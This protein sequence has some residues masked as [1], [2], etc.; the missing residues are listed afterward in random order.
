MFRNLLV[1][2]ILA[3]LAG[4]STGLPA[5]ESDRAAGRVTIEFI[6][7]TNSPDRQELYSASFAL[8]IGVSE[9]TNG[10]R[11]LPGVENDIPA[12]REA[13]ERHG[14][15]C[16]V[17]MN[18]DGRQLRRAF[19]D[20]IAEYGGDH[21]HRLLFYFAGHGHTQY[22][23]EMK[24]RRRGYIV[25]AP[26]AM[27]DRDW[28]EFS[29]HAVSMDQIQTYARDI[30][31][32]HAIFLFDSCF[33]GTIFRSRSGQT[34][35]PAIEAKVTRPVRQ[36]ITAGGPDEPVP[37]ESVFR[38]VLVR[39]LDGEAGIYSQD[40]YLTGIELGEH[41]LAEV[42]AYT[43]GAQTPEHGKIRDPLLDQGDF[44]FAFTG[45][46][47]SPV[48]NGIPEF[49]ADALLEQARQREE[50]E[51]SQLAL[52]EKAKDAWRT[53]EGIESNQYIS[54]GDKAA[55]YQEYLH[56]FTGSGWMVA[57]AEQRRSF[58]SNYQATVP[59]PTEPLATDVEPP[60]MSLPI[61][62][63]TMSLTVAAGVDM[64]F[65]LIPPGVFRMGREDGTQVTISEAF[66]MGKTE[67]TQ[68]QWKAVMGSNPSSFQGDDLPVE[69]VS[70]NDAMDFCRRLSARANRQVTLPT[71][72]QWEYACRAGTT[73]QYSFESYLE[74]KDHAWYGIN[75]GK[76]SHPVGT[77]K[78]NPWG[79]YD[80]HGN[81]QEWCLDW[82]A[83][84]NPIK[85]AT[86]PTGPTAGSEKVTRGGSFY[87]SPLAARS[88]ARSRLAPDRYLDN[89]G[90]R[91][92][93][94]P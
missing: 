25:A 33:A 29:R 61:R 73:T 19:E 67:V 64:E 55:K 51:K 48:N 71:E 75:S 72:A 31:S 43:Q 77:K 49:S 58:W 86:D 87:D 65:V 88:D 89:I 26:A 53:L 47:Q 44:V 28:A 63:E 52:V 82:Y 9:Y 74:I 90:F 84:Q 13:L 34:V 23:D 39:A 68:E 85:S 16:T 83:D 18:P 54:A 93:V 1:I 38:R 8:L 60:A 70:W 41:L 5:Q 3:L 57:L 66:W 30:V 17:V 7:E 11:R 10:W 69:K 2:L 50:A 62:L 45:R 79:L 59:T 27:P 32:D 35:P 40:G 80:I 15:Q 37:D 21:R 12:V 4:F 20:F 91:V 42:R 36:F 46:S 81:V 24:E 6:S 14:F 56:K 22:L 92:V 78:P 76:K 94:E